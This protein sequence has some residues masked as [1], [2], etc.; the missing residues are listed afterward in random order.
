[1]VEEL[2]QPTNTYTD[3]CGEEG[4]TGLSGG[5]HSL[6]SE[7]REGASQCLAGNS[8]GCLQ[9]LLL[10]TRWHVSYAVETVINHYVTGLETS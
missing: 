3:F 4:S 9:P 2:H 5:N 10:A 6:P 1:M 7:T 8:Q